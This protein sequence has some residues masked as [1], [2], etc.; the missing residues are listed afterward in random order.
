MVGWKVKRVKEGKYLVK[1]ILGKSAK[2]NVWFKKITEIDWS[3]KK[4][5][6]YIFKGEFIPWWMYSPVSEG[7][8]ILFVDKRTGEAQLYMFQGGE[9]VLKGKYNYKSDFE[10]LRRRVDELLSNEVQEDEV[11]EDN[12][13]KLVVEFT[14]EKTVKRDFGYSEKYL[15]YNDER[16]PYKAILKNGQLIAIVSRGYYL[17]ENEKLWEL[18]RKKA[19][20]KKLDAEIVS[21]SMTRIHIAVY[22]KDRDCAALVHNSVDASLALRVDLLIK[23]ND[24]YTVFRVRDLKQVYRRHTKNLNKFTDELWQ[25][26]EQILDKG[27]YYKAFLANLDSVKLKDVEEDLKEL[28]EV[29]PKKYWESAWY[30]YRRGRIR[31]LKEFYELV[32]R[33]VWQAQ[34]VDFMTKVGRFDK[35]NEIMFILVKFNEEEG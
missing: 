9:M 10:S 13:E 14:V 25:T 30:D 35:L 33:K 26:I 15:K 27:E 21:K 20:E 29:F 6:G 18:I 24:V 3:K 22:S 7:D 1:P 28:L 5:N 19:E 4:N 32:A 12:N 34:K 31:T 16:I 23:I 17:L 2:G 8:V 11:Q